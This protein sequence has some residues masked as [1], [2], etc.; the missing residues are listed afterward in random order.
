MLANYDLQPT[1]GTLTV[2]RRTLTIL[3]ADKSK[4]YGEDN[5]AFTG[6]ITGVQNGDAVTLSKQVRAILDEAGLRDVKIMASGDLDE[7]K[8]REIVSAGAP[9]DAFGVGTEIATSAD[10]PSMGTVYKLVE[11]D[12]CGIKR[13]TAKFSEQKETLPGA[14]QIFRLSGH[15][16]LGRSGE[17]CVGSE[18]LLRPVILGGNL[19]EPLSDVKSAKDRAAESLAKL[20]ASLRSLETQDDY[21]VEVSSDLQALIERT[22][23]NLA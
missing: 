16:V 15:D 2:T 5:P 20:P 8:I 6:S 13:F 7:Y 3:A 19:V 4:V 23:R 22:R 17:C 10:A 9:V 18:A 14:K 21:P 1:N 12:I 11:L